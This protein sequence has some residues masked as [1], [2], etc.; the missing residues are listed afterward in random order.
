MRETGERGVREPSGH[1]FSTPA[2]HQ[3]KARQSMHRD[4]ASHV[5]LPRH[6]V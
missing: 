3:L 1:L 6:Q 5:F 2:A 4:S